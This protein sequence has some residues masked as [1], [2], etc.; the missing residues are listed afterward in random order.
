M[1]TAL[2][3]VDPI[4]QKVSRTLESFARIVVDIYIGIFA[5]IGS[6]FLVL[7]GAMFVFLGI[8]LPMQD[9]SALSASAVILPLGL[10]WMFSA[11]IRKITWIFIGFMVTWTII[12]TGTL[13]PFLNVEA[14]HPLY[15]QI[16]LAF[17]YLIP[18]MLATTIAL[19]YKQQC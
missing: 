13:L 16:V 5:A 19:K 9:H 8:A 6:G 4:L 10:A 7:F 14:Q 2:Y 17:A 18:P 11:K 1:N 3:N 12:L 15:L